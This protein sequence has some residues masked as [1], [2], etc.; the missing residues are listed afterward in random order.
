M[1]GGWQLNGS[2]AL[3]TAASPA[4][5]QLTQTTNYQA[6]SAFW[7]TPVPGSGISAAF[8]AYIGPGSGAD[9][10]TFTLADASTSQPTALGVM[11][12]GEG[13]S[14]VDGIAVSLDT[15]QNSSDPATNFVGIATTNTPQQALNY[16]STDTFRCR[17]CATLSIT[18]WSRRPPSASS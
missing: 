14:G 7:P 1:A 8:D 5:L 2:A 10:M 9:G 4:N 16:V 3:V 11:G 6:G 13:F 12:G 18:S 15:W 17:R